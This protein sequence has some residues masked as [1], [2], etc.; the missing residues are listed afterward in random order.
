MLFVHEHIKCLKCRFSPYLK[1]GLLNSLNPNRFWRM[2]I[3]RARTVDRFVRYSSIRPA[4]F[5]ICGRA[6]P[7][8][9]QWPVPR[10]DGRAVDALGHPAAGAKVFLYTS[11]TLPGGLTW[12]DVCVRLPPVEPAHR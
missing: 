6:L 10:I 3:S 1:I 11:G 12:K 9:L 2:G 4:D 8:R 7:P 5:G